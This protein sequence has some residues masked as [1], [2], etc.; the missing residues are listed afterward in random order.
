[1]PNPIRKRDVK[2]GGKYRA[3]ISDRIVTVR[4]DSAT[5][6]G[7]GWNATNLDTGRTVRIRSAAKLRSEVSS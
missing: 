5:M 2:I 1:M 3:R 6:Y 4:I 7:T